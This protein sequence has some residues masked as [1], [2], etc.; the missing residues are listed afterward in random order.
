MVN[1]STVTESAVKNTFVFDAHDSNMYIYICIIST[2]LH[3]GIQM[4]QHKDQ[5]NLEPSA[6]YCMLMQTRLF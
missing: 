2:I 3:V 1:L 4:F 5:H 6:I